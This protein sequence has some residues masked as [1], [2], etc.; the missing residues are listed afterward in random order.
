MIASASDETIDFSRNHN[1]SFFS[2]KV[3]INIPPVHRL[4]CLLIVLLVTAGFPAITVATDQKQFTPEKPW[5]AE[6]HVKRYFSS[7]TSYEFGYPDPPL[8]AP[9]SRL[10]F[11]MNTWW[12][13]GEVRR[14]FSRFSVGA[15]VLGSIPME[16][17]L[18]FKD[19]DWNDAN[20]KDT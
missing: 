8:T 16:S 13:G 11:P 17:D 9:L 10:E 20:V 18:P 1:E 2:R 12:V 5:S 7:H 14:S 4:A 6:L 15:E 3:I 19:S